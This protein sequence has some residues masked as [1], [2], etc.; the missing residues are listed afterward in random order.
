MGCGKPGRNT[1]PNSGKA[2]DYR[3]LVRTWREGA[4]GQR[5]YGEGGDARHWTFGK[6]HRRSGRPGSVDPE[7]RDR[8][9]R[10]LSQP[11]LH[12]SME[13]LVRGDDFHSAVQQQVG[14]GREDA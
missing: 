3:E 5:I 10:E 2:P 4:V 7:Y 6:I 13:G 14:R 8:A 1:A 11:V 9:G 12:G